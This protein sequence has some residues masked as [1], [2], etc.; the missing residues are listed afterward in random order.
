MSA[1]ATASSNVN[2]HG[3]DNLSTVVAIVALVVS[4]IAL[5]GTGLQVAQQY[6]S[7]AAGYS[8]CDAS[9][10]GPW[11]TS[12]K[13]KFL[14]SE[15][16]FQVLF[17]TPVFFVC[18]ADNTNKPIKNADIWFVD[19]TPS[20]IKETRSLPV[21]D[22]KKP[23]RSNADPKEALLAAPPTGNSL[24]SSPPAKR[25][26]G[27]HTAD[28]EMSTWLRM[29][30]EMQRMERDSS[31]WQDAQ[32]EW[33]APGAALQF[34]HHK[35]CVAVQ[36][37]RMSWDSMPSSISRP[38]ATTTISHIVEM[39]A[40]LG[41]Y[42]KEFDRSAGRYRAEG[43]GY[44][45]TGT[46]IV[47]LGI[48]FTFQICGKSRFEENRIIP[49]DE[50]KEFAFGFVPTIFRENQDIRRLPFSTDDLHSLGPLALGSRNELAET[51]ASFGCNTN[52]SNAI[53]D[54]SKNHGHLF[55]RM[56]TRLFG[57]HHVGF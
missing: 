23:K 7:S 35:L 46:H 37:K 44:V 4:A 27:V 22:P 10:I 41:I 30:Q 21:G 52:T 40:M 51:L 53:R 49:A 18:A 14:L 6:L 28:S 31:Q 45:L 39:T 17:E 43:N 25:S 55:P 36:A 3:N 57:P 11:H 47:D 38:Y 29:L 34:M 26:D 8:K 12:K 1:N 24:A 56:L 20:S 16:R 33:N 32:V 2:N 54:L 5:V 50:T 48:V 13:R 9:V 42:W 15:M 19:G